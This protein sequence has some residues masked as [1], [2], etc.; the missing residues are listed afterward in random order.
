MTEIEK[1][2]FDT[3][4]TVADMCRKYHADIR[5]V[6]TLFELM[7]NLDEAGAQHVLYQ[8]S[9]PPPQKKNCPS[10]RH[11]TGNRQAAS[12]IT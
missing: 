11:D 2:T 5:K 4:L 3:T 9:M 10:R 1:N 8:V 12:C 7:G 6:V